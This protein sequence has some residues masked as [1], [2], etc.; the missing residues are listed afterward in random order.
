M[1]AGRAT[2]DEV[3]FDEDSSADVDGGAE[4]VAVGVLEPDPLN[5][6]RGRVGLSAFTE[7]LVSFWASSSTAGCS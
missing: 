6:P 5:L 2:L 1:K 4:V 7:L 3:S